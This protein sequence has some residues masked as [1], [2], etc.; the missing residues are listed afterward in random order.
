MYIKLLL[1]SLDFNHVWLFQGVGNKNMFIDVFKQRL[2]DNSLQLWNA[3][4]ENSTRARTYKLF[5]CFRYQPYLDTV[6]IT[7]FRKALTILR[8]SSHCLEVEPGRLHRPQQISVDERKCRLCNIIED[9]FLFLFEYPLCQ[10]IGQMH[11][12]KYF[13][14][15]P[16]VIRF[17]EFFESENIWIVKI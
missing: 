4:L 1:E 16:I 3:Q 9:E 13:W 5:S 12:K 8:V 7:K 14:K 6:K 2:Y 11:M 15:R 17:R 10:N